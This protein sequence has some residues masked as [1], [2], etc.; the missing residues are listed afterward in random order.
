MKRYLT[1]LLLMALFATAHGQTERIALW[2]GNAP[3]NKADLKV[4]EVNDNNVISKVTHP[5]L[6]HFPAAAV[7]G[8]LKPAI[9]ILPGGGYYNEWFPHEGFMVAEWFVKQGYEAFVLKYRLPDRALVDN[10]SFV[11]LMDGQQAIYLVRSRAERFGIDPNRI[12]I[13]GFSAGGHLA[14]SVSTLFNEPVNPQLKP[15][16]VRPDFSVLVYPVISMD[17]TFTHMG[18]RE[19]LLGKNPTD[20]QVA[21]FSIEKQISAQTPVTFLVHAIDDGLVPMKNS[22][23]YADN[24]FAK[25]GKVTKVILPFGGH[26]FGFD[27]QRP[28]GYWTG[29]LKT[30]LNANVK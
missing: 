26:G 13:I 7:D 10:A 17:S 25:G 15:A 16:D 24:L 4:E 19:N 5:E 20:E 28:I 30:W 12:G 3:F 6:L 22:D 29:Y 23:V 18:S 2:E 14:A 21:H 11:P 1:T 27:T 9:V 8:K